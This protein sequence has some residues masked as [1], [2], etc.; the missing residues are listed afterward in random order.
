LLR[1]FH[2]IKGQDFRDGKMTKNEFRYFQND[3]IRKRTQLI[4]EKINECREQISEFETVKGLPMHDQYDVGVQY[5]SAKND[6][7]INV[8]ITDIEE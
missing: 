2:N 5:K 6:P 1:L 3:W 8:K 4:C 7:T